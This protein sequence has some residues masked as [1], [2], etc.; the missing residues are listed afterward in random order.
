[1]RLNARLSMIEARDYVLALGKQR[2]PGWLWN[3]NFSAK[4][5]HARA[6][7]IRRRTFPVAALHLAAMCVQ[8][9]VRGHQVRILVVLITAS[10]PAAARRVS[11][12]A[13]RVA[14]ASARLLRRRPSPHRSTATRSRCSTARTATSTRR[15]A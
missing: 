4:S 3:R 13:K 8:R 9:F 12:A 6:A 7:I 15:R 5:G 14:A 11:A 1:M 2:R 10:E